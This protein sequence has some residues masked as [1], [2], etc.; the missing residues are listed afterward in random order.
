[1]AVVAI[2]AVVDIA[3]HLGMVKGVGIVGAMFMAVCAGEFRIVARNQVARRALAIRIAMADGERCVVR[4][5][6][7]GCGYPTARAVAV[8]TGGCEDAGIRGH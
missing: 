8:L 3:T 5:I 7:P 6:E 4:V 2:D 1:M